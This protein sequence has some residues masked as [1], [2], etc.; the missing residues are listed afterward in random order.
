[1]GIGSNLVDEDDATSILEAY[2]YAHAHDMAR[3]YVRTEAGTVPDPFI[4][5]YTPYWAKLIDESP[6]LDDGGNFLPS[7]INGEDVGVGI[8]GFDSDD[9]ELA[10]CTWLIPSWYSG[11]VD[12]VNDDYKVDLTDIFLAAQNYGYFFPG[13]WNSECSLVDLN[14]DDKIDLSDYL[15]IALKFGWTP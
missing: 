6:W 9:R 12:D 5:K 14:E 4:E 2:L 11:C 7:F 1:M 8:Y 13:N 15:A 10:R 3:K